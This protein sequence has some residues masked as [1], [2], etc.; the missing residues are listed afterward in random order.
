MKIAKIRSNYEQSLNNYVMA[1]HNID[2]AVLYA[3]FT[4]VV[5]NLT[6]KEH[7]LAPNAPFCTIIGNQNTEAVFFILEN[8]LPF[9]HL[10]DKVFVAPFA[11]PNYSSNATISEIN[12]QVDKNGMIRVKCLIKNNSNKLLE[13]M[14][15]KI[16]IQRLWSKQLI[17]PKSAVVL[18]SNRKVV[19]TFR[20]NKALW[21]YIETT[22]ENSESYLVTQG[23]NPGDSIIYDGNFNLAH[24]AIV[25]L[26]Q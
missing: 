15:V 14:N 4:G 2:A 1:K 10:G 11:E 12:P 17:V 22:Q 13:G 7:N 24:E 21:N 26:S 23:L 20:N 19:F 5:A 9:V 25:V 16:R 6:E 18:R 3:P 8:E